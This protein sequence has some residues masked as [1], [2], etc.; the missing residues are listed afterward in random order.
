MPRRAIVLVLASAAALAT[1]R[2]QWDLRA[3]CIRTDVVIEDWDPNHPL[4]M[5]WW[6]EEPVPTGPNFR[7]AVVLQ[8]LD[9]EEVDYW[10]AYAGSGAVHLCA[11]E[12]FAPDTVYEW[13]VRQFVNPYPNHLPVPWYD[14]SGI[15][16]FRTSA[17]SALD[18]IGSES[19]CAAFRGWDFDRL[20]YCTNAWIDNDGDGWEQSSDC[21]DSDPRVNQNATEL[22]DGLDNDCDGQIDDGFLLRVWPDADGDGFG[23]GSAPIDLVSC[24][25]ERPEGSV[26]NGADCDDADAAVNPAAPEIPGNGIDDDCTGGDGVNDTG[27]PADT[28]D[29]GLSDTAPAADTGLAPTGDTASPGDT[30]S[31]DTGETG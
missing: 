16:R 31:S 5:K 6:G 27:L 3:P 7:E 20:F 19:A 1:S 10:A 26:A 4:L 23:D 12:G 21:D 2:E 30:A 25:G 17:V 18:P 28:S 24:D 8:T 29:T 9:G 11:K 15:V 22:C 14:H 13:R